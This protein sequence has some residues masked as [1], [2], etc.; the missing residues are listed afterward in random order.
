MFVFIL[1]VL[2]IVFNILCISII[3]LFIILI[4]LFRIGLGEPKSEFINQSHPK[5]KTLSEP[6]LLTNQNT[7]PKFPSQPRSL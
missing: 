3:L 6:K 2:Y 5:P 1:S 7:L 4:Y